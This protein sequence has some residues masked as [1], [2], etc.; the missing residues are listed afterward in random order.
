[1][2]QLRAAAEDNEIAADYDLVLDS[3]LYDDPF[4]ELELLSMQ[5]ESEAPPGD[6][7]P[8]FRLCEH[9]E[10][11]IPAPEGLPTQA[12]QELS[13]L[14]AA[15]GISDHLTAARDDVL[16]LYRTRIENADE[17]LGD[18]RLASARAIVAR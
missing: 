13:A 2:D 11:L 17:T 3:V 10:A 16:T 15:E 12:R 8:G 5:S 9:L 4:A 6:V 1:M 14:L 18:Y 7:S